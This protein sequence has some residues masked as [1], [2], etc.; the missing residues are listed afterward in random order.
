MGNICKTCTIS[1]QTE[2]DSGCC[3]VWQGLDHDN[4]RLAYVVHVFVTS[5]LY[6]GKKE[7]V[8]AKEYLD[9]HW[10]EEFD[11]FSRLFKRYTSMTPFSYYQG[12]KIN[13][14]K[15][16]LCDQNLSIGDAFSA[17]G[18]DYNG[19]YARVVK[20]KVGMTP[21]QYRKTLG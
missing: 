1:V 21:S 9:R 3:P 16:Q 20:E 8:K 2:H 19:N 18:L 12:L 17:C 4:H 10:L 13:K 15:E 7:I 14:L 11:H 5:K 6:N